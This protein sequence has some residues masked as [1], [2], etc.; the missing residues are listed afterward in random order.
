MLPTYHSAYYTAHT[1]YS[2]AC[3]ATGS[4]A[5]MGLM[6]TPTDAGHT[7]DSPAGTNAAGF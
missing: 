6:L 3:Y 5:G 2:Y 7:F 4:T 1:A